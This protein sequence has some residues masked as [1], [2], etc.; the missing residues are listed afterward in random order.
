MHSAGSHFEDLDDEAKEFQRKGIKAFE[1]GKMLD[2]TD[3]SI[4]VQVSD[5]DRS[6]ELSAD[7][8]AISGNSPKHR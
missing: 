5:E 8:N 6:T 4:G 2:A 1:R 7:K 3:K